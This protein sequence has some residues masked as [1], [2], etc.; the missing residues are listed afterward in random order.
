MRTHIYTYRYDNM[1]HPHA[2]KPHTPHHHPHTTHIHA[3]INTH[4]PHTNARTNTH[5][6][7]REIALM[8]N[9][10]HHH[11]EVLGKY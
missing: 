2:A 3:H 9:Y 6:L 10:I 11:R 8:I 1:K 4:T 5:A 7:S